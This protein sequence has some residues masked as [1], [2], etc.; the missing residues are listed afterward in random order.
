M[1]HQYEPDTGPKKGI[2][3]LTK[4]LDGEDSYGSEEM[5]EVAELDAAENFKGL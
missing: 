4:N 3:E 1:Q 2:D 5:N